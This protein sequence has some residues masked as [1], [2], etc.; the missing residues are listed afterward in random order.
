MDVLTRRVTRGEREIPLTAREYEMLQYLM[1]HAGHPVSREMLAQ[2]VWKE[3]TRVT[4]IDNVIDVHM[5]RLRRKVDSDT[6][7]RLLH[8]LRGVGFVLEERTA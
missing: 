1:R 5:T 6:S 2:D 7:P 8:T 4:P 3:T